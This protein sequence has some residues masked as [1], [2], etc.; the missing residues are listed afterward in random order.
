MR[1][2]PLLELFQRANS[3]FQRVSKTRHWQWSEGPRP[4]DCVTHSTL[5]DQRHYVRS[6]A[7][8]AARD[9]RS[10]CYLDFTRYLAGDPKLLKVEQEQWTFARI[11]LPR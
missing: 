11:G 1:K 5:R 3:D 2:P 7:V 6:L 4:L 8:F 9:D 10:F